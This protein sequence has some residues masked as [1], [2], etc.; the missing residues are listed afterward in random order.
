MRKKESRKMINWKTHWERDRE[1][2]GNGKKYRQLETQR[3]IDTV[4]EN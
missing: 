1:R 3:D 4:S 2:Y